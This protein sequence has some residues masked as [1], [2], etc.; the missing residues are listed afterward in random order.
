MQP[1]ET[2][3]RAWL[4]ESAVPK[5][6]D[7][8]LV[9]GQAY[10]FV[11]RLGK[12]GF[13]ATFHVSSQDGPDLVF[14]IILARGP[15]VSRGIQKE[16]ERAQSLK[17][18]KCAKMCELLRDEDEVVGFSYEY[19]EGT[20]LEKLITDLPFTD[21]ETIRKISLEVFQILEDL[22]MQRWVHKDIKPS[23]MIVLP[24]NRGVRLIDFGLLTP[25]SLGTRIGAGTPE[26]MAPE[27]KDAGAAD[28]QFDQYGACASLLE[29]ILGR[30][31][32]NNC[33]TRSDESGVY[34][35]LGLAAADLD[36]LEPLARN[37]AR[38]L[39][40]G[41]A[42]NPLDRP[43]SVSAMLDLIDQVDSSAEPDG[44]EIVNDT[45][46]KLLNLRKGSSGVLPQTDEFATYT[47][48]DTRLDTD[49]VPQIL[50]G[51]F[52]AI[53]LSGNPGDGKTTFLNHL[54]E[55]L[56]ISGGNV[57]SSSDADW[58][59]SLD[60]LTFHAMLDASE[61]DGGTSSDER[62]IQILNFLTEPDH[63]VLIAINDG[64]AESFMRSNS[65]LFEFAI[66][67]QNQLRGSA[68]Q[69]PRIVVIDLKSRALIR[70]DQGAQRGL[71]LQ[72]LSR[73][74]DKQLWNDCERCVSREICPIFDNRTRLQKDS[75]LQ[76]IERLLAIAHY[77]RDQRATIRDI[78]SVFAFAITG[79]RDCEAV[80]SARRDGR[81]LRRSSDALFFDLFFNGNSSDH[82]FASFKEL[83]PARM[84]LAQTARRTLLRSS[85]ESES[86]NQRSVASHARESFFGVTESWIGEID[87]TDWS[88]YRFFET[89]RDFLSDGRGDLLQRVVVGL[90]RVMGAESTQEG[91]LSISLSDQNEPWQVQRDFV[92]QHFRLEVIRRA[93]PFIEFAADS[94]LL[95]YVPPRVHSD[96]PAISL[97]LGLDDIELIL[98]AEAGEIFG[99]AYSK[100]A[101]AKFS[102]FAS[103][104]RLME[105]SRVTLIGPRNEMV[106][107]ERVG[108]Q[109]VLSAP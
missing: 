86:L 33:F 104:L 37:L 107:A 27:A 17:N 42:L 97:T 54:Y 39:A 93:A 103:T 41:L 72:I 1:M 61:S 83:D 36:Q 16:F 75:A 48:V 52:D 91:I 49:L 18:E 55:H 46:S 26:Y 98:R 78:R 53:F 57:Q 74:T 89:Y 45:V 84:P 102:G 44:T 15:Q 73:L 87:E 51:N 101:I 11:A 47:H 32:F 21:S 106:Q 71:G 99:D 64:R 56:K 13:G 31:A 68:P 43:R 34:T 4:D 38:Q 108:P 35:F 92:I 81:D 80:H 65:D 94:L 29:L 79:D 3:F 58:V 59:V 85:S 105:S 5:P 77:R 8:F 9:D 10:T 67:I 22:H 100:A 63:V 109:I 28:F 20:T 76:G 19:I 7:L 70:P 90:T 2:G 30:R 88:V 40:K 60:K 23:N 62:I 50:Q 14:K 66:D 82:L 69:N 12:G 24:D 25:V 95:S 6:G 96:D